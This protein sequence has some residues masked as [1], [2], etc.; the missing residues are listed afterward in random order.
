MALPDDEDYGPAIDTGEDI[1]ALF[2]HLRG[3]DAGG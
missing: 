2:A 1:E 3:E